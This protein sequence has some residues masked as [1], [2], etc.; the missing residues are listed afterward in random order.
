MLPIRTKPPKPPKPP[1][2]EPTFCGTHGGIPIFTAGFP[3]LRENAHPGMPKF[4]GCVYFY[5]TGGMA[6]LA[7]GNRFASIAATDDPGG[8]RGDS[9]L[10]LCPGACGPTAGA[11]PG[12]M[13][14]SPARA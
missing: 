3:D 13:V 7:C 10:V 9:E 4:T 11:P 8:S 1:V 5:D 12:V 6:G 2:N 14:G